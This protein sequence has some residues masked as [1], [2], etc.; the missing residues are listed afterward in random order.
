M[1]FPRLSSF[2][3]F[4]VLLHAVLLLA[5]LLL[6]VP[7]TAPLRAQVEPPTLSATIA[8]EE[9]VRGQKGWGLSVFAGSKPERFEVEVL[10]VVRRSTPELSYILARISG[11]GLDRSGVAAGMSGSPVYF[12]GKL[13]GAVAYSYPFDLDAVAGITPIAS[14][15]D[16]SHLP[17]VAALPGAVPATSPLPP[18]SIRFE[19]LVRRELAEDLLTQELA[20]LLPFSE[21]VRGA[22]ARGASPARSAASSSSGILW[23]ANGFGTRARSLLD[24]AVGGFVPLAGGGGGG[25]AVVSGGLEAGS[26][27]A[28]LLVDG[29]MVMAAHGTVTEVRG[30]EVL[31]FGHPLFS[32][33]PMNLPMAHSEVVTVMAN[34]ASSFKISNAG[35]VIGAFDQDRQ[36]GVRGHLGAKAPM[37]P[38]NIELAG[39]SQRQY[40]L[41]VAQLPSMRP[42]LLAISTLGALDAASYASGPQG[43]DLEARFKLRGYEDLVLSQSFDGGSAG[44]DSVVYL[45]SFATFL[46]ANAFEE[47]DLEGVDVRLEQVARPRMAT[48]VAAHAARQRVEPGSRLSVTL[49]FASWRG[50]RFRRTFEVTI[51]EDVAEGRYY[52]LLGDGTSMDAARLTIERN[53][54]ENFEQALRRLRDFHSRK[55]LL[56]FGLVPRPGLAVAGEALPHLPGSVRSIFSAGG[57][58]PSPVP[59]RLAINHLQIEEL[60]QPIS[61]AVRIDLK[62]ERRRD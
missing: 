35:E 41:R 46:D 32:L 44:L 1:K 20:R 31:A 4:L 43:I 17:P 11:H 5:V 3:F 51:P 60:E 55:E 48:L 30:D 42:V 49:E 54:P 52:I 57:V 36:A 33:G 26:A 59:L 28:A 12:D 7:S 40:H 29:D 25:E 16:L 23:T 61:G 56:I 9:L 13:A 18:L 62:V 34:A 21:N 19:D 53:T 47:V 8:P 15:R 6:L 27:V 22:A 50:D 10:G 37:T 24:Q 39:L 2:P 38:L 14:M 45:L 58:S